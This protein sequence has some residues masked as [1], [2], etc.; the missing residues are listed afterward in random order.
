MAIRQ[1]ANLP[2]CAVL[3]LFS[4]SIA[5][6]QTPVQP[7]SESE[8]VYRQRF[9]TYLRDPGNYPYAPL[10][11]LA[12]ARTY[13]PL[14]VAPRQTVSQ[15][16]LYAARS[17][18]EANRSTALIVWHAGRIETAWYGAGVTARTPLVSKSLSKPLTAIAV[19]RAIRLG[20][21]RS[22]DQPIADFLPELAGT[23]K[24]RILVRH[25]LDM[26][27][28][29][30]DQG[31]SADPDHPLNRCYLETDHGKCIVDSYPMLAEPG[32][33]YAYANAP[34]DLVALVIER[35][36]HQRFGDFISREVLS[37][38]GALGGEI[39]VD[40]PGGLAHS[41]CCTYLPAETFLRMAILL[42]DDGAWHG[43]RLLPRGYVSEMRK[44]TAQNPNFGLSVWLGEPYRQRR[45]FGAPGTAGPQVLHSE[46][47]LDPGMFLFDGNN[48]QTV[49][50][51]PKHRLIV[52]RMGATPPASPEWDNAFLPNLLIRGLEA[53]H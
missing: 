41:G 29:M 3:A 52:L 12:G 17:Y 19:G 40:R 5:L 22:L 4:Q 50:I 25:L 33:R 43:R 37:P 18:A 1:F 14:P 48:N 10:E 11:A 20:F 53:K 8:A 36:T 26:R 44:G 6:A 9:A 15:A 39:W 32:T 45:G 2:I 13:R 27:S 23:Q 34:S 47:Y 38:I 21:I 31:F 16:A 30:L 42:L 49:H 28:G 51:S 7:Q 24:G 46:P 35:A